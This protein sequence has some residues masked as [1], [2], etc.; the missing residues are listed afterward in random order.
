M[1][2]KGKTKTP[3]EKMK[4]IEE[5][6]SG[7]DQQIESYFVSEKAM[8]EHLAFMANFHNYSQ[9]NMTLIDKQFMGAQAVGSFNFWKSKGAAVQKG[10]KGIKI[11]VPTP[12]QFFKKNGIDVPVSSA[13][14]QERELIDK[15][16]LETSKKTFFKIG[17]VF[18]YTQTNARELNL[19]VSEVFG[20][21]H[22][23]GSLES[24]KE[25]MV[26]LDKVATK[27]DFAIVDEAPFEL[28]TAKGAAAP[29]EKIIA[30]N[31]RNTEFENVSVLIHE[32]AHAKMHAPERSKELST[33][34]KEFQ[35]EMVSYVV[36]NR[37]GIDTEDF[38]LSYLANWTQ[39]AELKDKEQ[40]LNE[41]R[42]TASEFIDEIDSHFDQVK[43]KGLQQD[44]ELTAL[45][46]L[47]MQAQTLNA[48][49]ELSAQEPM[50]YIYGISTELQ[51]FGELNNLDF[52]KY[53]QEKIAYLVAIPRQGKETLLVSGQYEK[54]K[55]IH[56]LHQLDKEQLVDKETYTTLENGYHD[57]L[58][59]QDDDYIQSFAARLRTEIYKEDAPASE[60]SFSKNKS[61]NSS[62]EEIDYSR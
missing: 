12:V 30:L 58:L 56:P 33:N 26:A 36:A 14:K 10:E 15:K 21:Y 18:E 35:A 54:G 2:F 62:K 60:K 1:A 19:S 47:E 11:L 5:L 29:I 7:M 32:L 49:K 48:G 57:V 38:T 39:G 43:E 13:S 46:D 23:D 42:S 59:K 50:M 53:K 45:S 34:E 55:Y 41:V 52:D 27:L 24:S 8:R 44:K 20:K 28:G 51:P 4:E 9:R 37:Y 3:E 22:R 25:M 17:H 61:L 31:P 6:T 16:Q 40:L